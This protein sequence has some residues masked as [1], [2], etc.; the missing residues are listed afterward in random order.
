MANENANLNVT[1]NGENGNLPDPVPYNL[2][3][4]QVIEIAEEAVKNGDIPGINVDPNVD[5]D[6]F[7]VDR[8]N[9]QGDLGARIFLR[10]KVPFG[11]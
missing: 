7:V 11:S 9:E 5:F 10:S 8:F 4:Q 3:D 6:G 1:W 2:T